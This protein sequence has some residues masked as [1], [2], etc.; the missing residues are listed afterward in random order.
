[1]YPCPPP[2]RCVRLVIENRFILPPSMHSLSLK[3]NSDITKLSEGEKQIH[4]NKIS[5]ALNPDSL[6]IDKWVAHVSCFFHYNKEMSKY[7]YQYITDWRNGRSS[8]LNITFWLK[9]ISIGY[10]IGGYPKYLQTLRS[11]SLWWNWHAFKL[12]DMHSN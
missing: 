3:K 7:Q 5:H 6:I 8:V 4:R 1:M 2:Q 11:C 9:R 12:K 10:P